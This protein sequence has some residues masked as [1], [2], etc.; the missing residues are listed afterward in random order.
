MAVHLSGPLDRERI[1]QWLDSLLW[2]RGSRR[3]DV[4]RIKGMLQLAG[5]QRWHILQARAAMW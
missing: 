4:F 3:E 2:E 5:S 1:R